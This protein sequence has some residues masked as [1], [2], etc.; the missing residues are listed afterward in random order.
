MRILGSIGN[1]QCLYLGTVWP[2]PL[3]WPSGSFIIPRVCKCT[4]TCRQPWKQEREKKRKKKRHRRTLP[5]QETMASPTVLIIGCG[6][7]GPVVGLLLKQKGYRPLLFEKAARPGD[8]GASLMLCPNGLK[9]LALLDAHHTVPAQLLASSDPPREMFERTASGA[10]LGW[11]DVPGEFPRRFGAPAAGAKR[12]DVTG[13]LRA[14]AVR[15]G[16]EIRD[17]WALERIEED[18]SSVTA[19]F[20]GAPGADGSSSSCTTTKETGAFLVGCDGIKSTVRRILLQR[21]G[22]EDAAPAFTGLTQINGFSPTPASFRGHAA[23]RNWYGKALHALSYP[24][25]E[26]MVSWAITADDDQGEEA[27]WG[28]F[29]DEQR[30]AMKTVWKERLAGQGWDPVVVELVASA[31][32]MIKYGIYDRPQLPMNQWYSGRSVMLG[33]AVHPTSVH[34]GQGANQAWCV[35]TALLFPKVSK[36]NPTPQRGLLSLDVHA[37]RVQQR[38]FHQHR[39]AH[40]GFSALR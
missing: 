5:T 1:G 34:L 20:K 36:A 27:A 3:Y 9:V 38:Y 21:H 30:A 28:L 17:G 8:V 37:A 15:E 31:S 23:L 14:L 39:T 35:G 6:V 16:V 12:T 2:G 24:I 33:D 29:D 26:D 25:S 32:R 13:W 7:A 40:R 10:L 11:A 19:Y 22:V 4:F 18:A